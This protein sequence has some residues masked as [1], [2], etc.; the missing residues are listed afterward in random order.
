MA[1]II[2]N[3]RK[4]ITLFPGP[5]LGKLVNACHM[6]INGSFIQQAMRNP[7]HDEVKRRLEIC[8]NAAIEMRGELK[9]GMQRICDTLPEVL[10]TELSGAKWVP[11]AR[12]R[13]LW[14]PQDGA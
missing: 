2:G 4:I 8:V 7:T 1:A 9:W 14:I 13:S 10:R 11:A 3:D 12:E 6:A 5:T